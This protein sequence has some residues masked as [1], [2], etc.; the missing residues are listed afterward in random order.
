MTENNNPV[1]TNG[2]YPLKGVRVLDFTWIHAGPATTRIMAEQGAEVIKVESTFAISIAG[3]PAP[4]TP[5]G[6]GYRH[7]W[8]A[9]KLSLALNMKSPRGLEIANRLVAVSDVVA[10]NFSSR[11]MPKWSMDYQKLRQIKPDIIMLSM[12]GFGRTGPWRDFV[13]YGQTLQA[14]SGLTCLTGFPDTDPSGPASAYCD[15]VAGE[16]GAQA[17]LLAL[18]HRTRTGQGQWI[19]LSQ[20]EA[21][22]V[23]LETMVLD[24]SVNNRG[25]SIQ[26]TGNRL[27][28]G[29]GAPHG[30][31]RCRGTEQWVAIAVFTD[32]EW[33][34][35]KEVAGDPARFNDDR[36]NTTTGRQNN[37]EDL[38]QQ[39]E[40][41]TLHHSPEEVMHSLQAAG[42]AAGVIQ[43]G[44]DMLN[45]DPQLKERG[46]FITVPDDQGTP[47]II[48][49]VPYKLSRTPGGAV[50]AAPGFGA[51][52]DYILRDVL[53]MSDEELTECAIEGAFE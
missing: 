39:V 1:N 46:Y 29:G 43:S 17:V 40:S 9:N 53:G 51:H 6:V 48:D 24:L 12:S 16:V 11:V 22:A 7:N 45:K 5:R 33:N 23:L 25:E 37:A 42:V 27:P 36:F 4:L 44:M 15:A 31:Y 38:D 3:G 20:F 41:W 28:H 2:Q 8:N 32:E 14:A 47:R 34:A 35:F 30:A 52:Q 21:L 13:S 19:D 50:R 49:G 26:R 10:E 18:I